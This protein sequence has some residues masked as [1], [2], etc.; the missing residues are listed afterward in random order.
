MA[1]FNKLARR[2]TFAEH[3]PKFNDIERP[4]GSN[5]PSLGLNLAVRERSIK[6]GETRNGIAREA[7]RIINVASR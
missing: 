5:V 7:V 2:S 3:S 4:F 6:S 1:L